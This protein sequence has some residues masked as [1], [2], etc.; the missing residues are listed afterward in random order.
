MD[1][2]AQSMPPTEFAAAWLRHRSLDWAADLLPSFES[3]LTSPST[4]TP[5]TPKEKL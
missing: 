4:L 3:P 5:L 1:A 2:I